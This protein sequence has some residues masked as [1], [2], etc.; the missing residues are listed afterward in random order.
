MEKIGTLADEICGMMQLALKD[1]GL[2]FEKSTLDIDCAIKALE[3]AIRINKLSGMT[4]GL[5]ERILSDLEN[6][7]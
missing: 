6:L 7:K 1:S 2:D 5:Y 3:F 4:S